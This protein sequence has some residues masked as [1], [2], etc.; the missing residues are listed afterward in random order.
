[1][2][3]AIF[4][5]LGAAGCEGGDGTA[6]TQSE[7]PDSASA[8]TTDDRGEG[9]AGETG[10]EGT[11]EELESEP[12]KLWFMV[13]EQFL[14]VER[15]VEAEASEPGAVA[16]PEEATEALLEGPRPEDDPVV[17]GNGDR[18][19]EVAEGDTQTAIPGGTELVGFEVGEDGEARIELSPEF[20]DGIPAKAARRTLEE[21]RELSA[22]V[23]Q[24]VYTVTQFAGISSAAVSTGGITVS[25]GKRRADYAPPEKKG[26]PDDEPLRPGAP[27]SAATRQLQQRLIKLRYLP[28]GTADGIYGDQ[29]SQ[30]VL[31]F[32]AWEGL[33]RDGVAGPAT[34]KALAKAKIPRPEGDG[35]A[36]RV[37]IHLDEGV[38][39]LVRGGRTRRAIHASPGTPGYDTPRGSF[40]VFRK[41]LMSWSVPYSVWMPYASYFNGGIALHESSSVPA[42]PAS[43]GCV[44]IPPSE[45]KLVYNFATMGTPVQVL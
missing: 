8:T 2:A 37:E 17:S 26:A 18:E 32:Q 7:P 38:V 1:M 22:R 10:L 31:A 34:Q 25:S 44:R 30:A 42:Y 45:A 14:P 23:G 20:L 13:G 5:A 39:L 9:T 40:E 35:P 3:A 24:V 27:R 36:R 4:V 6:S 28:R 15:A 29:T 33:D 43:H 21:R 41:E 19:T 11:T 16:G 12:V